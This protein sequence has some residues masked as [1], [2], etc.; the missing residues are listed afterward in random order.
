[1]ES[2]LSTI[3]PSD[4]QATPDFVPARLLHPGRF[5]ASPE[6][7]LRDS[8]LDVQEKRAILSSWA[9]D[10]CAVESN[11]ALRRPPG[12]DEPIG[13]DVIMEALQSLDRVAGET[14]RQRGQSQGDVARVTLHV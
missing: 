6:A 1:M 2:T 13:F 11:P 8:S 14:V 10:A 3:V 4:L 9:S 12:A 7:L 5:Y